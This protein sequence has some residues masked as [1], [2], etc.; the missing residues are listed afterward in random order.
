MI[1]DKYVMDF[2]Y[3]F[4][5]HTKTILSKI[6]QKIIA[7]AMLPIKKNGMW[8]NCQAG[9]G[10]PYPPKWVRAE[11]GYCPENKL[12]RKL[13][14]ADQRSTC[15]D[16]GLMETNNPDIIRIMLMEIE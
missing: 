10:E 9:N 2:L 15:R 12:V 13:W 8:K 4:E 6:T 11:Y 16:K 3:D 5:Y 7:N 14:I 1:S